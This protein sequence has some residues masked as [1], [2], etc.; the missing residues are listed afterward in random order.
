MQMIETMTDEGLET[1][2]SE[3]KRLLDEAVK[4]GEYHRITLAAAEFKKEYNR[5]SKIAKL[6][7]RR[8]ELLQGS[9]RL[10]GKSMNMS[11]KASRGLTADEKLAK[12]LG[13]TMQQ[14]MAF[15]KLVAK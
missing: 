6:R 2:I 5:K 7:R 11:A 14:F 13:L 15:K 1:F 12:A 4:L 10:D 9:I 3:R 8:E